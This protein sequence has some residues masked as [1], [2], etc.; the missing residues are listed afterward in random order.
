MTQP[1]YNPY[2]SDADDQQPQ[3]PQHS[4]PEASQQPTEQPTAGSYAGY[5]QGSPDTAGSQYQQPYG[6]QP[7]YQGGYAAPGY[8]PPPKTQG[9]TITALI[10]GIISLFFGA[11]PVLGLL[12]GAAAVIVSAV[13]LNKKAHSR[14][15]SIAGLITGIIG[16]I[17]GVIMT[18]VLFTG[19]AMI[20]RTIQDPSFYEQLEQ[21]EQQYDDGKIGG[22]V[23]NGTDN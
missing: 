11:V 4:Y 15:M 10:L 22:S 3:D 13:A 5:G 9:I 12:L 19:L 21:I 18:I 8:A 7:Q 20:E 14:G 16:L 1:P 17:I 2:S 23:T 6:G